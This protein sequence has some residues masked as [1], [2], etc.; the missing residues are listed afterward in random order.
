MVAI[1][2]PSAAVPDM[3]V[4]PQSIEAEQN[5]IG[6]LLLAPQ[7]IDQIDFLE[8]RHFY[9][10]AHRLSFVC[11]RTMV[12]AGKPVDTMLLADAL[13]ARGEL[14]AV[15][16]Q[17][18]LGSLAI[19]TPSAAN[20][21][22]YAEIV[23]DRAIL[24]E[25][26]TKA[27]TVLDQAAT[28]GADPRELAEQAEASFLQILDTRQGSDMVPLSVAVGEAV[29]AREA[30]Q[31]DVIATGFEHLDKM[32]AGGGFKP[33]QLV[34]VAARVSMGK[35]AL[36]FNIAE[37]AAHAHTVAVFTLEMTRREFADRAL[38]Y[39]ESLI[40]RDG[41]VMRLLDLR[42]HI[43]DT[44]AVTVGHIRLR[45]RRI[46][47]KH[48]LGLIVVDYLQLMRGTGENR[49]QEIG[50][51]SRGLKALAKELDV[52]VIA[53]AQINRAVEN[54]QDK[55]PLLS[56][57]R[58]SGDIEADAD[59][60][61]MIYRDDVYS[62]ESPMK[63]LAEI[64]IRK[65]RNGPTGTVWLTFDAEHTRFHNYGGE[66]PQLRAPGLRTRAPTGFDYKSAQAGDKRTAA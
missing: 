40:G 31:H 24:R 60:V 51:I 3:R 33:G 58:E 30:A 27:L 10:E 14:A 55:H 49:T 41:G 47:R 56:D 43:D 62:S 20:I 59:V 53:V 36:A 42:I 63:G 37:H 45:C 21:R 15:G 54:R 22:C 48:G 39:H 4:P 1:A 13:Q 9:A 66:V 23:R 18:Y 38:A 32:L 19:N 65:Q 2:T 46:K 11:I 7:A 29:D 34:I 25:L 44:P 61:M 12:E 28:P 57:L 6:G 5:V 64:I 50:S 16:G 8:A 26:Q 17:A 52:P 35:S